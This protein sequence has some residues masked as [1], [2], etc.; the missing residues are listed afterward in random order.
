MIDRQC[1][2]RRKPDVAL[3]GTTRL[4]S[5]SDGADDY[6]SS[7]AHQESAQGP[8]IS[9]FLDPRAKRGVTHAAQLEW[10]VDA[11][12]SYFA[13][14][15]NSLGTCLRCETLLFLRIPEY[16]D[17]SS[18]VVKGGRFYLGQR[19]N[20]SSR[21]ACAGF[22]LVDRSAGISIATTDDETSKRETQK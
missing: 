11:S 2:F 12:G 3:V 7:L 15:A 9:D 22:A 8:G 10:I 16:T 18:R 17:T 21:N 6:V 1:G 14:R 5:A 19:A 20:H 13:S 4:A